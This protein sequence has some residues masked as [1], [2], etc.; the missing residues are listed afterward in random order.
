MG[1]KRTKNEYKAAL[2]KSDAPET[3]DFICFHGI[4]CTDSWVNA[5]MKT[6]ASGL[7]AVFIASFCGDDVAFGPSNL[8]KLA[9]KLLGWAEEMEKS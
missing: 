5:E 2:N 7:D 3:E 6:L 4:R 1:R 8:R 9:N